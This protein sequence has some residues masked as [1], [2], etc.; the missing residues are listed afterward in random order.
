MFWNRPLTLGSGVGI[1]IRGHD[2]AVALVKSQWKGVTVA[3]KTVLQDFRRR[4]PAEWG[5]EYAAFLKNHGFRNLP[6]VLALPREEVIVRLLSLPAM[7]RAELRSAV[8]FQLDGLHPYGEDSV[9][10]SFTPLAGNARGVQVA[11]IIAPRPVVD[12]YAERLAEAG[13]KLRGM[14]VAAA[15]YYEIGRAS[16]RE[17]VYVLV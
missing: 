7:S 10:H 16:C 8:R 9:Y 15:G 12:G 17:R 2:L 13:V 5:K 6:A 14:T 3:G 4:P 11:V 1:E